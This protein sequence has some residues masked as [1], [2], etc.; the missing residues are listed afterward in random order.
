M[1]VLISAAE[2]SAD[3]HAAHLV[4]ALRR[5]VPGL[6]IA[7]IGGT[8]LEEQ[9]LRPVARAAELAVMGS[10][11]ILS[12]LSVIRR[13]E[14]D[15]IREAARIRPDVAVLVDYPGFHFR[16]G[17]RLK[18]LGIPVVYFIP[19]KVWVWRSSRLRVMREW[20]A[21]VLCILPFE[22]KIYED[23]GIRAEFV[24]SPLVEE[25]PIRMSREEARAKLG[26]SPAERVLAVLPGSRDSEM[27]RHWRPFLDAARLF[28][29]K[30]GESW[31]VLVPIASTLDFEH[32]RGEA[33]SWRRDSGTE[34]I[35]LRLVQDG[36]GEL[37]RAADLGLIKSGTST[38][39]AAILECPMVVAYRPGRVTSL[40]VKHLLRY[41]G[42]VGLVNLFRGWKE[43]DALVA[44]EI[45]H[46]EMTAPRLAAELHA[47]RGDAGR[48]AKMRRDLAGLRE[49]VLS[50][51]N[52]HGGPSDRAAEA[53]IAVV[54]EARGSA[55]A[56]R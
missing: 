33:E 35:G 30:S 54:E 28:A 23:A 43:G 21:R 13:A 1:R 32:W 7:G 53:V 37:L 18:A 31:T 41:R 10:A 9:G 29:E 50:G 55:V 36:S 19:P 12:R 45:L 52:G 11:E 51:Q 40:A 17:P 2:A 14:K 44:P 6:E 5:R 27:E 16:V 34:S 20:V 48:L 46:G 24:G 22:P 8:H 4:E 25:L 3:L 47:L 39:E 15:L 38:L 42:P 56:S 49:L 26:I